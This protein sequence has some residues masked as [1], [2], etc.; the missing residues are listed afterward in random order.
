MNDQNIEIRIDNYLS[1]KM[2]PQ[3]MDAFEKELHTN[4]ELKESFQTEVV[5]KF[6]MANIKAQRME[7]EKNASSSDPPTSKTKP[8]WQNPIIWGS[9]G[10]SNNFANMDLWAA[11]HQSAE[12]TIIC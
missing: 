10:C 3:E 4:P 7:E 6:A 9:V 5:H 2:S 1:N 11:K 8:L 12:T